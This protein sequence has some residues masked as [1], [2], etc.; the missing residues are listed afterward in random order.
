[1]GA[2][3]AISLG[4]GGIGI[5]HATTS[6]GEKPVFKPIEP[7][8]LADL[9]PAPFQVGPRSAAL[10]PAETYTLSGWGAVGECTLPT[11]TTG[12]ALNVTAVGATKDTF[13]TF[14]PASATRPN[15]SNLNPSPG[16]PP[17]P[18]AVNIDID[19]AGQ[20][21]VYNLDGNVNVII[22]VVGVYD[23]HNHD[24]RYYTEAEVNA[25]VAAAKSVS[26]Y[27]GGDQTVTLSTTDAVVRSVS[28]TAPV[29][30][31]VIVNSSGY[32]WLASGTD[33]IAR[34]SLTTGTILDPAAFQYVNMQG[35]VSP[36][37]DVISGTRGFNVTAGQV[38]TVNLVCDE[39]SGQ[40]F[41][42]DTWIA[43]IFTPN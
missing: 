4:A 20:F 10:G 2:V 14:F 28:I 1:V 35:E 15:A 42:S 43:A 31:K 16:Q 9:R 38:L 18:N 41:V 8:R 17:T 21:S 7:C 6:S 40:A 39:F 12:L 32:M 26:A 19:A 36:E 3:L 22:D 13:L 23:D 29:D 11:G 24:D 27:A 34:C 37:S 5:T 33:V 30:G 25:A